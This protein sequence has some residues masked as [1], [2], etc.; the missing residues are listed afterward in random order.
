MSW[1][2]GTHSEGEQWGGLQRKRGN[3]AFSSTHRWSL[4]T[5][6]LKAGGG[7]GE[8]K[9]LL[10]SE[11]EWRERGPEPGG[12]TWPEKAQ[13]LARKAEKAQLLA[14]RAKTAAIGQKTTESCSGCSVTEDD[15]DGM[16]SPSKGSH[17]LLVARPGP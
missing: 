9:A 3:G 1:A 4:K 12:G 11:D 6:V 17:V 2:N 10:G 8:T 5:S 16:T 15:G 14:G 13:R 7:N